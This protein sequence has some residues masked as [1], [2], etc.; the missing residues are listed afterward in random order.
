M[1]TFERAV[2]SVH[3]VNRDSTKLGRFCWTKVGSSRKNM[4]VTTMYMPHN[5]DNTDTKKHMVRDQHKTH[6]TSKGMVNKEPCCT[7]FEDVVEK[8]VSWE[9]EGC[10][11]V[12]VGDFNE[13]IHRGKFSERLAKDDLNML[14]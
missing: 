7:L 2:A 6:Y 8:C 11:I 4:H 1:M 3:T 14:E 13:D 9:Q 10:E 12:L 5:K